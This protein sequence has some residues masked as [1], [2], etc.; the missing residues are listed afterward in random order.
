MGKGKFYLIIIIVF[1]LFV[2]ITPKISLS[3][4]CQS[5]ADCGEGGTCVKSPND[6]FGECQSVSPSTPSSDT[7]GSVCNKDE[8]CGEN[9]KCLDHKCYSVSQP[10]VSGEASCTNDSDCQHLGQGYYCDNGECKPSP[11]QPVPHGE[12]PYTAAGSVELQNPLGNIDL[13]GLIGGRIIPGLL[14]IIGAVA[15]AVII[16]GGFRYIV[17]HGNEEEIRAAKSTITYA[18][19]G[20]A[21]AL[22]S[23]IIINAVVGVLTK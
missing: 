20:L 1:A 17:S 11:F 6:Q 12:N 23:W 18:I 7:T 3:Q 13:I 22:L 4:S 10:G 21:F 15:V 19:I 9:A 16:F 2:A 14:G 5:D 8:D